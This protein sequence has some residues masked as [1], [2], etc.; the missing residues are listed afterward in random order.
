MKNHQIS[1][2]G[3]LGL[4]GAQ[5]GQRAH[6]RQ[7]AARARQIGEAERRIHSHRTQRARALELQPAV[8]EPRHRDRLELARRR[9]PRGIQETRDPLARDAERGG[10]DSSR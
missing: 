8:G 10:R 6:Q 5:R 3:G 1:T 2:R 9:S 7:H 4:R